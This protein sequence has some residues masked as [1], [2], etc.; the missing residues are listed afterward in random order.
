MIKTDIRKKYL[1]KRRNFSA[2]YVHKNSKIIQ[3]SIYN[4]DWY[5]KANTIMIYVSF[6][7]EV[8]THE[9][10]NFALNDGKKVIVSVCAEGNTLIPVEI[11][12]IND[13]IPNKYG[14]LEP[15][16]IE[17]Y[18]GDIDVVVVPG[19]AFDRYF[20]RIGFGCGY[21]DRFLCKYSDS[22]KVGICFNEQ[23]CEKIDTDV[24]DISMDIIITDKEIMCKND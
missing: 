20:N 6:E 15:S 11:K 21:Y 3:N 10:I 22:L 23:I 13:M 1:L 12:S 8:K 19:I 14:I 16:A 7:N 9:I 2:E 5:K 17:R 4:S 24:N 18:T